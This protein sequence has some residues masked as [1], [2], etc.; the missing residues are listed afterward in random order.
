VKEGTATYEHKFWK[1]RF[2]GRMEYRHDWSN[3]P[4]FHKSTNR[5]VDAQSTLSLGMMAILSPGS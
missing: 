5:L 4:F 1:S 3:E 2:L